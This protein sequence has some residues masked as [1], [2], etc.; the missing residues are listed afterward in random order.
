MK[1][2]LLITSLFITLPAVSAPYIGLELGSTSLSGDVKDEFTNNSFSL[3]PDTSETNLSAF[4][5]YQFD[6]NW[7]LELG[8]RQFELEDSLSTDTLISETVYAEE[9]WEESVEVK[10]ISLMPVYSYPLNEK[11]NLKGGLGVTYTQYEQSSEYSY[12]E[13][14]IYDQDVAGSETSQSTSAKQHQWGGIASVGV[15]YNIAT[16]LS[17]GASAKYH[18]DSYADSLSLNISTTYSF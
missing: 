2:T 14:T 13:E 3:N 15:E 10:Q 4:V 9:E 16:N 17:I 7:A 6:K 11:W 12:E 5:G 18:V 1:K 8:Y